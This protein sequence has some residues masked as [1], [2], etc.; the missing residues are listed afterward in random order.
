M[1]SL[2]VLCSK[3]FYAQLIHLVICSN[4]LE[5][6]DGGLL[7]SFVSDQLFDSWGGSLSDAAFPEFSLRYMRKIV[8][9]LIR[10][11]DGRKVPVIVF[12][13]GGGLWLPELADCG[14]D[15]LGLDWTMN[16]GT[17]RQLVGA[18]VAL[19]GNMDPS[20]LYGRPD[21]IR[22]EVDRILRAYGHGP[23]HV[24]N[25]GHGIHQYV[26]PESA[27]VLVD[28]VHELSLQ[29]HTAG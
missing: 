28:A 2:V 6:T 24:F 10:E 18:R 5:I 1:V 25:L 27:R 12:T 7:I 14:A 16:L 13:K 26:E 21:Q 17:A 15:A 8:D 19:Q 29:Y 4:R 3:Q 20:V 11:H 9:G 23:G 22:T